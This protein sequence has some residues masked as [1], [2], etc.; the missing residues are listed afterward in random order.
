MLTGKGKKFIRALISYLLVFTVAFFLGAALGVKP[1]SALREKPPSEVFSRESSEFQEL[2]PAIDVMNYIR[3][4]Y[5]KDVP[6]NVLVQGAIKGMVQALGDPYSVF[7]DAEEFQ[8]FMISV[9][10]SFEGV[11]LSLDIDEETGSIIVIAPIEDTPAQ[12]AGIRPRDRIVK[13][14]DVEL[15]GKTLDEAVKLLRGRKGTKVTVYIERPGVKDLLKYELVRDDIRLKTVKRDV[16]GDDIGYVKITSFDTHTPEE[17][18]DALSYLRQKGVKALVL[19]LRNNPGGSLNAAV[20]VADALMG[21]GLVV[22]TEDR[23]GHRLEEY[24]SDTAS[25]N[26]PLAVLV[27]ENSASAAEIVAGALQD[28]GRGVLVGKKTFGKG[29]VQELT[30]LSNGSGLKITIARYFLPSG[31]SIDGKGVEPNVEVAQ[32]KT[33][34]PFDVP[35]EKDEQLKK[36]MDILK[37]SLRAGN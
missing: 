15:K 1:L 3:E 20:E 18:R 31:R 29:T 5:I 17:F 33:D 2:K 14:D 22:F 35:P 16:L 32:G 8:D 25:L 30:P 12:R 24:Y 10:G 36:A 28:T 23:Y 9:N 7:M 27:N 37:T 4:R 6:V 34:N 13:V 11:G 26:M 19:D 21:K